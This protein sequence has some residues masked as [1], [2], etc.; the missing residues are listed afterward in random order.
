M[1]MLCVRSGCLLGAALHRATTSQQ[2]WRTNVFWQPVVSGERMLTQFLRLRVAANMMSSGPKET[3]T[4]LRGRLLVGES[5]EV[6][7]YDVNGRLARQLDALQLAPLV[8]RSLGHLHWMELTRDVQAPLPTPSMQCIE[9]LR[10][11]GTQVQIH[12]H[13]GEPYWSSTEIV[14]NAALVEATITALA[15]T[16][17]ATIN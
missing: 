6:A 11:C 16:S 4:D 2:P 1:G 12:R 5:V 3:L 14:V 15:G 8:D 13:T 9:S 7:G 10:G 17:N